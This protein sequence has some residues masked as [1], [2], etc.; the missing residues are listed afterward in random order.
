MRQTNII[1]VAV[2]PSNLIQP[3]KINDKV[4]KKKEIYSKNY[5]YENDLFSSIRKEENDII[6]FHKKTSVSVSLKEPYYDNSFIK[7]IVPKTRLYLYKKN[8]DYKI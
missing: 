1:Y 4:F 2:N 6:N 8:N 3:V 7:S 5:D